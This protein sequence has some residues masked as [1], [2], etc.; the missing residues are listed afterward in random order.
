MTDKEPK[1]DPIQG[2]IL[3]EYDG[4]EEADN[5][6]PLWWV[7]GFL[8]TI[9]FAL[10]Y[11]LGFEVYR[12]RPT[13]HQEYLAQ[14]QVL[15][16]ARAAELAASPDVTAELLQQLATAPQSVAEGGAVFAQQCVPCHGDK[17][18]GK[19]GPNLTDPHWLHGG[20]ALAIHTTIASGVPAKG[21]PAWQSVLGAKA[22]RDVTAYVLSVRNTTVPGGKPPEGKAESPQTAL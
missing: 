5:Q 18:E 13:P 15:A 9:A 3:H 7:L 14:A 2:A 20:D 8:G 10:A 22:V 19:I 4:I 11:W 12:A 6:L 17:A 21:M 1:I 16:E